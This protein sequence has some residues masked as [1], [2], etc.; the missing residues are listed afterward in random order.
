MGKL[1][2]GNSALLADE[3]CNRCICFGMSVAPDAT[4]IRAD[5]A[6]GTHRCSLYH[7][8]A[9]TAHSAASQMD[10]VPESV[11]RPSRLEYWHIGE[12]KIRFRKVRSR[13]F[14]EENKRLIVHSFSSSLWGL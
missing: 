10:Q 14:R 13:N 5:P 6:F 12:T 2:P 8:Q 3:S 4:V 1:D 9:R 11:G 7:D